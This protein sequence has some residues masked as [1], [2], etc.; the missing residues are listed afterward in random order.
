MSQVYMCIDQED[1]IVNCPSCDHQCRMDRP[2]Y[3]QPNHPSNQL[4]EENLNASEEQSPSANFIEIWEIYRFGKAQYPL[5]W[6]LSNK[7]TQANLSDINTFS[8]RFIEL[9]LHLLIIFWIT[10]TGYSSCLGWK[11]NCL[12]IIP[13]LNFFY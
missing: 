7:L 9:T 11:N 3:Y 6:S 1:T 10:I 4:A 5:R 8:L 2:I 12:N 13:K